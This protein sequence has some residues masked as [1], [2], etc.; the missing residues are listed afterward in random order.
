MAKRFKVIIVT[1]DKTAYEGEAVSATL[2]GAEGYLGVW[3][4][5]AAL[6]SAHSFWL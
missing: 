1:P 2:P 6:V 5:H 3:A 4:D